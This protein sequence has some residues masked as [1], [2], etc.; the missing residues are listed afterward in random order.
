MPTEPSKQLFDPEFSKAGA[1]AVIE[2]AC[3]VLDEIRNYGYR[4]FARSSVRPD[5]G[6][7]NVAILGLFCH[8]L[9]MVDAARIQVAESAPIP[10]KLQLRAIFEALLGLDYMLAKDTAPGAHA[11]VS[12]G[13]KSASIRGVASD[14]ILRRSREPWPA[15]WQ[16]ERGMLI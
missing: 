9:K 5:G 13:S 6:D 4:L 8:L 14:A 7:E 2:T 11:C 16:G 3:A 10:A 15:A 12:R 1:K